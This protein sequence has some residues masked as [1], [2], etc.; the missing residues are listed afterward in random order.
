[1]TR[2]IL[3][4]VTAITL[5]L[6]LNGF[7]ASVD[8]P[9]KSGE[10][11]TETPI[12]VAKPRPKVDA[13][14]MVDFYMRD[15]NSVSG[16]LLSDDTTQIVVEQP[17]DNTVV[18]K[19]YS[20]K[21]VDTR[22]IRTKPMAEWQYYVKLA[23]YFSA[24]TWDFVDDPDE[25]IIAIRSYEKAKQ[26]LTSSGADND[27]IEDI[28]KALKKV[29]DDRDVWTREVEPRAKLKRLEYDAEAENRLKKLEKSIGESNVKMIESLK[30]IDKTSEVLKSD[31]ARIE[32]TVGDFNKDTV[33]Q[34][35]D[36][37]VQINDS[38]VLTNQL[39]QK[40]ELCCRR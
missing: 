3:L 11:R 21:E 1:M 33:K 14:T 15:G 27:K 16:R 35:N 23:E 24:K 5:V 2:V 30:S 8:E 40:I 22:S 37:Q 39:W 34:M 7:A 13:V 4:T 25:F 19:T 6:L 28:E 36:L 9:N 10:V 29:K 26:L 32:K 12:T 20:K 17:F 31:Y 38:R 18:T